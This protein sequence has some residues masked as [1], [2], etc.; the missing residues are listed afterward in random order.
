MYSSIVENTG[1]TSYR[2]TIG[3][4]GFTM[5][6]AGRGINPVDGLVATLCACLGHYV[7]D[8]MH[9]RR[10][11]Y[12]RFTVEAKADATADGLRLG[13]V[14]VVVAISGANLDEQQKA[15]LLGYL[16]RCKIHNTLRANSQITKVVTCR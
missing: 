7:R 6:T 15:D 14:T 9:D 2:A 16:D 3:D 11:A 10:L 8:F 4:Y 1:D 5:D 13:D 12:S